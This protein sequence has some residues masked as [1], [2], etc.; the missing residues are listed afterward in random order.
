MEASCCEDD[1]TGTSN[2]TRRR[3]SLTAEHSSPLHLLK[4]KNNEYRWK[5]LPKFKHAIELKYMSSISVLISELRFFK[6]FNCFIIIFLIIIFILFFIK[7][8]PGP[9]KG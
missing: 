4:K 5:T 1:L 9:S 6:F 7:M 3:C 2:L 8:A